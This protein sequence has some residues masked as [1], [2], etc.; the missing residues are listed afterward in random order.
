MKR[1][2]YLALVIGI[3]VIVNP[4]LHAQQA[5]SPNAANTQS[6]PNRFTAK[7]SGEVIWKG[8]DLSHTN[9]SAYRDEKLKDLYTSGLS[10][11]GTGVF[12]IRVEPG[13]Y[14]LV[15]YVD[16]DNSGKFDEGDGYGVL[17]V[18]DWQNETQKHQAVDIGENGELKGIQIPITAR[19]QNIGEELK[20]V[21]ATAYQ[22]TKYQQ[23]K[24][25][26]T[27]ATSGCRGILKDTKETDSAKDKKLILAYTD[28]SWKYRAGITMVDAE[29]GQ[30]ELRLKPGKY[31][32]MAIVDKNSNNKLDAGDTFGFYGVTDMYKRGAFPEPILIKPN[33]FTENL[34]V[35]ISATYTPKR[36]SKNEKNTAIISGRVTPIPQTET[37]IRVEVY[38]TSAL[39][40]PIVSATT[41]SEG[42]F[43]FQL[44]PGEYYL[45]ANHDADGNGRYSEGDTLGALG[46][47]SIAMTPPA[48]VVF[49]AG[50]TRAANIQMSARYDAEGQLVAI[51][52]NGLTGNLAV[53]ASED[54]ASEEPIGRISGKIT[55]FFASRTAKK[56]SEESTSEN[57]E[58]VPD[59]ILSL[60][61]TPDFSS[62]MWMPLFLDEEGRYLVDVK[63][64]RYYIMAVVDRNSDGQ[65]GTADGIGIF[66]THQ[67]V[68]GTP[69]AV[70]V[71]PGKITPH[72]DID[73]LASYVDEKGTMAELSDGGRW[74]IARRFG[75]PED[76]F[77]YT[78]N[79]KM[80]EEWM[81]WTKGIAFN[82]E[83]DGAGWK[84]KDQNKFEPK[85]QNILKETETPEEDKQDSVNTPKT[86]QPKNM[87][88][89]GFS[90]AAESVF[91][92]YSHEGVLWRIAPAGTADV[93][94]NVLRDV[95]VDTRVAPLGAGF[96]PSA[97]ENGMLAFHDFD[98]NVIIRDIGRGRNMVLLDN[99]QL[100]EDV[101]I[102]P[103]G[104]YIAYAQTAPTKRKRIVIQS[105]RNEKIFRIPSTALEMSNPAWRPD[106][107]LIAYATAG[108][109]ENPK[110]DENRNIYAFDNVSNSVEPIVISPADDAE[111]AWH[112]A[113]R[114]TLAFSR[115]EDG[116]PRQIWTVTFSDAGKPTEKQITEMGG[117]RPVWVP[118]NGRWILYENNGQLWTVDMQTPG[119]ESPLM[120]NGKAV[121]GYQPI[122]VWVE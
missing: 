107:E 30:W 59:G 33:T 112:P 71:F 79:G 90:L 66:G 20:L 49:D 37:E 102:S 87:S 44:P 23:F 74:N 93:A 18:K 116:T 111:P 31:Y 50:E 22:P 16:V 58:L 35:Q 26:L 75:E 120:S 29:T 47:D 28:T 100:A 6:T 43:R 64:G 57:Q 48:A 53:N 24:T 85:T 7:L 9:V 40:N 51:T 98:D 92:Y 8:Q 81:Y 32:L 39:V 114:N 94:A 119:S 45:I 55:S 42:K 106:G 60:S 118:P 76:I 84:L 19:L 12:E 17:G 67:P 3:G 122:A 34:E 78:E 4:I 115:G 99:R 10:R 105:L 15:A 97:S 46:T 63:P 95:P 103:N 65:S 113:E 70:T 2:I 108:S 25:E 52:N 5:S 89:D 13:R 41:D 82:F 109:I 101:A 80:V 83:A 72:V 110:A 56:E 1:L 68:R 36:Q 73:I 117:S 69:A 91:I 88:V 86:E 121:F 54:T 62:P 96:R 61:T 27:R 104:E 21:P 14:Y 11:S 38:P 77:K